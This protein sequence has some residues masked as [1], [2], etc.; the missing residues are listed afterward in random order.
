MCDGLI[1]RPLK[2]G[3]IKKMKDEKKPY[4]FYHSVVQLP[5]WLF[6]GNYQPFWKGNQWN[7]LS[8]K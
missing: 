2:A 4:I 6:S 8:D 7:N 1:P 3:V 5:D